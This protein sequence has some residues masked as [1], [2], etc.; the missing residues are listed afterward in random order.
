V[1]SPGVSGFTTAFS[2]PTCFC[3][4]HGCYASGG[5]DPISRRPSGRNV[6]GRTYKAH[7]VA[8]RQAEF[9]AAEENTEAVLA[10]Q[11]E[12]IT[13][14]LSASVLADN[15]SGPSLVPGGPLWSRNSSEGHQSHSDSP[16][17]IKHTG[18]PSSP[19]M[20]P[21]S[22]SIFP[23]SSH[24]PPHQTG[25][26]RSQEVEPSSIKHTG[27]PSSPFVTPHSPLSR[28]IFSSQSLSI[29]SHSPH[30]TG[31]RYSREVEIITR[32]SELEQ[33]VNT[34]RERALE[35]FTRLGRPLSS[36]PPS[37][38]PLSEL[39]QSSR[40]LKDELEMVTSK[41]P[42]VLDLKT[43]I[44]SKLQKIDAKLVAAKKDWNQKLFDI[45]AMNTPKHGV[46]CETGT[47]FKTNIQPF[48]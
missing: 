29:S 13:A 38:F 33:E 40:S 45:K 2:M 36:G 35:G 39:L 17:S 30:R 4:S 28:S 46:P 9:R 31:S 37:L 34:L 11:I 47:V 15:V 6:D 22:R 14:H 32:L 8:D 26:R 20:T 5:Q 3:I 16:T 41:G 18:S 23:I 24:S 12:E 43:S 7:T 44:S 1:S 10:V 25:S 27:S 21:L 42:A 48:H 19:S